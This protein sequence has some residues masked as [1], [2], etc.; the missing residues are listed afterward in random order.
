[1]LCNGLYDLLRWLNTHFANI[2]QKVC[3]GETEM[4]K[5]S[6]GL[7]TQLFAPFRE[8]VNRLNNRVAASGLHLIQRKVLYSH[9]NL[10]SVNALYDDAVRTESEQI[11]LE[12]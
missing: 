12:N 9:R 2:K 4:G 6:V 8:E 7:G 3:F 11:T 10:C 1:M 5:L